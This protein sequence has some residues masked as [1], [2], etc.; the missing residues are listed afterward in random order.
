MKIQTARK[1]HRCT[2]CGRRIP[3]GARYWYGEGRDGH[4]E[5]DRREHGNCEDFKS[6][7]H[8]P[9]GFNQNRKTTW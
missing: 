2:L 8:L 1:E 7:P 6:E 5:L 4:D 3:S 9:E